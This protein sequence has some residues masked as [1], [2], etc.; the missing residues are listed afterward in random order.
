M[1]MPIVTAS[2]LK[3]NPLQQIWKNRTIFYIPFAFLFAIFSVI[4]IHRNTEWKNNFTLFYSGAITAPNSGRSHELIADIYMDSAQSSHDSV[5][6]YKY[7]SLACIE[8]S[9]SIE[10]FYPLK[11]PTW[12]YNLGLSY[13]GKGNTDSALQAYKMALE[14][15]PGFLQ[16]ANNSGVIYF[17]RRLYD[18]ALHYF[19]MSYRVDTNFFTLL[20]IGLS[21][22][23][24][25]DYIN[26]F[27]YD[28]LVLIKS[29]GNRPTLN[30][31]SLMHNDIGIEY[32]NKNELDKASNE[33][34]LALKYD[35][36]SAN[37]FGN[38]GV[39]YQKK[40]DFEMA[41]NYY[42]K[43]ILKDPNSGV[44]AKYLQALNGLKN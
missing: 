11:Y 43:A 10:H 39:V 22:Q 19:L 17:T 23:N 14:T 30:N 44:F 41:K 34:Y 24:E 21:Y 5:M 2:I 8:F 9:K 36:N 28:S 13:A 26:A 7:Y 15:D 40:G 27:H 25:H 29:P 18:S 4:I 6:R 1:A 16:S 32:V 37:A 20:N 35:S 33:F 38:L 31:L 3:L 12:Y 42:R